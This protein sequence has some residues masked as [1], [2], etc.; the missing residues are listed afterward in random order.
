MDK[1]YMANEKPAGVDWTGR[2]QRKGP[3]S[4]AAPKGKNNN[5]QQQ[6]QQQQE[7]KVKKLFGLF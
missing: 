6:Q 7:P 5:Q 1:S 3:S 4:S 2:N